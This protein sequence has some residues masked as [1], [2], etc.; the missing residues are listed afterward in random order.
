VEYLIEHLTEP[1]DLVVDPTAGSGTVLAAARATGRRWL[2]A[3]LD[4]ETA[5][6]ARAR[7]AGAPAGK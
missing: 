5:A 1:G 2:G 3:E 7:L 4:P 6:L